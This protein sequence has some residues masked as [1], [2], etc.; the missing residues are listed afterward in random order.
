[1]ATREEEVGGAA[2][3]DGG[4][5]VPAVLERGE[6]VDE[7]GGNATKPEVAAPR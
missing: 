2:W 5:G 4:S 1:M 6:G 7:V 3:V